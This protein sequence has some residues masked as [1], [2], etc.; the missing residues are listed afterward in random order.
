TLGS[1]PLDGRGPARPTAWPARRRPGLASRRRNRRHSGSSS[2]VLLLPGVVSAPST[3]ASARRGPA[4]SLRWPRDWH[5][6][7]RPRSPETVAF[8]ELPLTVALQ[9]QTQR[10]GNLVEVRVIEA[11]DKTV[12]GG[13][14]RA[15]MDQHLRR[16]RVVGDDP[17]TP[18]SSLAP[19][20]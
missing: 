11:D 1:P 10:I 6:P 13:E 4:W 3:P 9:G 20:G 12:H 5:G 17:R 16:L 7:D 18:W 19:P 2:T 15:Y 14:S 8:E